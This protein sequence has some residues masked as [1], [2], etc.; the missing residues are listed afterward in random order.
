MREEEGEEGE[1][2]EEMISS[3]D[4]WA[5]KWPVVLQSSWEDE[6]LDSI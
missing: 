1:R 5:I 2:E 4:G 6:C 3:D